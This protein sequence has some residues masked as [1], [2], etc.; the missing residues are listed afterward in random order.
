METQN[1]LTLH[2]TVDHLYRLYWADRGEF[3]LQ[4]ENEFATSNYFPLEHKQLIVRAFFFFF[5]ID[6]ISLL[7]KSVFFLSW[8]ILWKVKWKTG[9]I[10][11]KST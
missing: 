7:E 11:L 2:I 8:R 1:E 10:V 6:H 9:I 4:K 5:L 3:I